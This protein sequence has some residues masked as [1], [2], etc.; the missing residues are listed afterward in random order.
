MFS[1]TQQALFVAEDMDIKG[2]EAPSQ[3]TPGLSTS[4]PAGTQ[5]SP[6][7]QAMPPRSNLLRLQDKWELLPPV[8]PVYK[9]PVENWTVLAN[10]FVTQILKEGYR[11]P[12]T[13]TNPTTSMP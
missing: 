7:G 13:G 1:D 10:P 4:L 5:E 8:I 6:L 2:N 3:S 12:L 11:L 9:T